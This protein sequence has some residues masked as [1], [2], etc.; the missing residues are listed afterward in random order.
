[1]KIET[2]RKVGKL[3]QKLETFER[4][5]RYAISSGQ[6]ACVYNLQ[7]RIDKIELEIENLKD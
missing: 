4:N 5:K 1:M 6:L 3:I 7:S 2:A